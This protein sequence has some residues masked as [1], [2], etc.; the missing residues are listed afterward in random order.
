M[1]IRSVLVLTL[2]AGA[3]CD[4]RPA[5]RAI[6]PSL[7]LETTLRITEARAR[8]LFAREVLQPL[9]QWRFVPD[10]EHYYVARRSPGET[11]TSF[12]AVRNFVVADLT[13][14][15]AKTR[16]INIPFAAHVTFTTTYTIEGVKDGEQ[17]APHEHTHTYQLVK[18]HWRL[19]T[20]SYSIG[21]VHYDCLVGHLGAQ[22][23]RAE[24]LCVDEATRLVEPD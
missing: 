13:A 5:P 2:F 12:L 6:E 19:E 10:A 14:T 23:S 17:V 24:A 4:R 20:Q 7:P 21:A 18:G 8:D 15:V 22:T 11:R 1:H 9:A 3:A 16:S